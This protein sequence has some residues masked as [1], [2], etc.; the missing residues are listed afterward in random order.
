MNPQDHH[1][2]DIPSLAQELRQE[3]ATVKPSSPV[4]FGGGAAARPI[5]IVD[6]V[7]ELTR[8]V[9]TA[10]YEYDPQH[11]SIG[12]YHRTGEL[13]RDADKVSYLHDV[14]SLAAATNSGAYLEL[15]DYLTELALMEGRA[16]SCYAHS[17]NIPSKEFVRMLLLDACF[18]LFRFGDVVRHREEEPPANGPIPFFVVDKIHQLAF[19]DSKAPA[20]EA[21]ASY[22]HKLLRGPQYSVA[23]PTV[24]E[25]PARTPEAANLLHLLHMHFTPSTPLPV[26]GGGRPVGRWRTATDYYFAGVTFRKRVLSRVGAAPARCI[27]D[28]KVDSG[29]GTLEVPQ[30]NIDAQT[31]RLLP[32]MMAMEQRNPV[33]SGSHVTVY[34]VFM[35]QLACT[36][37]DVELLVRRG[38]IVHG[39]G[40]HG[41]V[42]Q[43]FADLWKGGVF[44]VNDANQNYLRTVCQTLERRFCSRRWR[45]LAWLKQNYF[46]NPWLAAG[47]VA[48]AVGLVCTVI[49]AVYTVLSYTKGRN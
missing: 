38:V 23:T 43:C 31:W 47:L 8:N 28:V 12:P 13:V 30:L 3:L 2:I 27:L 21:V 4:Q 17:F 15:E 16:R 25:P 42:S 7:G 49:Q 35:T 5:I 19:L 9:D 22:A 10:K 26:P 34:C 48:A 36:P 46:T 41:E 11:I 40:N 29:G 44:D 18:I 1:S 14:L 33:V 32:N 45:W 20:L 37:R 6:K 39:L 24:V